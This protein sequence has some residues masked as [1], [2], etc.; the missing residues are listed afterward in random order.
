MAM[1]GAQHQTACELQTIL[2]TRCKD[3]KTAGKDVSL[4]ARVWV[5]LER[6]KR[7]MRGIPPLSGHKLNELLR[8]ARAPRDAGPAP[9]E[10]DS[11]QAMVEPKESLNADPVTAP[12][13]PKPPSANG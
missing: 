3:G 7:E 12:P 11:E 6:M 2:V 1:Y 5:E 13:T 8:D 9:L 4:L 10:L